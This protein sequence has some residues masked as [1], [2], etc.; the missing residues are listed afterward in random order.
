MVILI[1]LMFLL[2]VPQLA[3]QSAAIP[4]TSSVTVPM[5]DIDLYEKAG[6]Y[7]RV[8][9][10]SGSFSKAQ[11]E[12]TARARQWLW[13]HWT[14][15]RLGLLMETR[16]SIEGDRST[17]YYFVEPDEQGRWRIGIKIEHIY[18]NRL[19]DSNCQ[20]LVIEK[21]TSYVVTRVDTKFDENGN[22]LPIAPNE[23]RSPESYRIR[24]KLEQAD[25][26]VYY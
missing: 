20:R 22:D 26:F 13:S 2:L 17:F 8:Q 5:K 25:N 14:Q 19:N 18:V 11:T 6:P 24:M 21:L 9:E 3:G 4:P 23:K 12:S 15:Q 7:E 1:R 10:P 16:Y